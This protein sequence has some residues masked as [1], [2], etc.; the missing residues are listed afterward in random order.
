MAVATLTPLELVT[1][2]L[3]WRLG[4]RVG[5]GKRLVMVVAAKRLVTAATGRG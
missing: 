3:T 1:G 5:G 4:G 2:V